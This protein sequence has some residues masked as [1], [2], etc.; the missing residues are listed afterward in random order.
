MCF[1]LFLDEYTKIT[2]KACAPGYTALY[3]QSCSFS[4]FL[5]F[6]LSCFLS[7][8]LTLSHSLALSLTLLHSLSLFLT[9]SH[10]FSL[11]LT[12]SHSLA[13]SLALSLCTCTYKSICIYIYIFVQVCVCVQ[14]SQSSCHDYAAPSLAA[15]M[16]KHAWPLKVRPWL[17]RGSRMSAG[18]LVGVEPDAATSTRVPPQPMLLKLPAIVVHLVVATAS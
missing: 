18:C 13:L 16:P 5:S 1:A 10:S 4:F 9:L 8:S 14:L 15:F 2:Q 11:S 17:L 6:F 12:L 7:L 3:M